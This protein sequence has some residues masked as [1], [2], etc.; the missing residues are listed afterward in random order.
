[1][2]A[3]A[4]KGYFDLGDLIWFATIGAIT[5]D[6]INYF[7]GK[8]YGSKIFKHGFWFIKPA[9]FKKGEKFFKKH[10]SK[11]VFIFSGNISIVYQNTFLPHV[12]I[13][14]K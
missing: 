8:K 13:I 1:M 10:G 9:H 11:S 14:D 5:G 2:G 6:N 7:I 3:L 12:E 4:A